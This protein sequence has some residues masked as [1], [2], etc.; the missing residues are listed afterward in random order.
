MPAAV[1]G[2]PAA[3]GVLGGA[4]IG[5]RS[6]K[7]A[8]QASERASNQALAV[9]RERMAEDRRRYDAQQAAYA[10]WYQQQIDLR[11]SIASHYGYTL[12]ESFGRTGAP[13]APA[14]SGAKAGPAPSTPMGT[15]AASGLTLGG[16]M[17]GPAAARQAEAPGMGL[18]T[19]ASEQQ[20]PAMGG[21][22]LGGMMG[23]EWSNWRNF[24]D[25]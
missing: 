24:S 12:P 10:N 19:P 3:V 18:M 21:G 15:P 20:Q 13:A 6:N 4:F 17:D 9:E 14:G 1:A 23:P 7:R 8:A 5:D 22:T 25:A 11:R 2:I 16:I